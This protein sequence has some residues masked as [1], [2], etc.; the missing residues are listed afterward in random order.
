[1]P[2]SDYPANAVVHVGWGRPGGRL[3][4]VVDFAPVAHRTERAAPDRKAAG[5]IPAGRT[6]FRIQK[7]VASNLLLVAVLQSLLQFTAVSQE[8]MAK[9][10]LELLQPAPPTVT[11]ARPERRPSEP[12]PP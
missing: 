8:P 12:G 9:A 2:R 3:H 10:T 7:S 1:M 6:I 5:S 11:I 4:L